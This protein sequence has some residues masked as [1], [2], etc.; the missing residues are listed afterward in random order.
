MAEINQI[1]RCYN[2]GAILQSEDPSKEGYVKKET[3]ENAS[4]NFLFCDKCFEIERYRKRS[5]EPLLEPDFLK[6][7]E[8]VK[9]KNA[10]IVY[11]VNVFSFEAS[12]HHQVLEALDGMNLLVVANKFDLL[13]VG[14]SK[15]ETRE[16]VAH[17]FR[18]A[19]L[20]LKADDV[21]LA[22]AFDDET[23]KEI[24]S[25]IYEMKNGRDV[26]VV[27]SAMSGKAT[28]ISSFLRIF[29]NLSKG[30]IV[31]EPY[32]GTQL[33]CMKIPFNKKTALYNTPGISMDNSVLYNIDKATLREIY[34][35]KPVKARDIS[36]TKGYCFYIGGIAMVELLEG[37]KTTFTC[38]FHENCLLHH[39][40]ILRKSP[41]QRFVSQVVKKA[42][43][44]S[45][46]SIRSVKD[47]DVYD[48]V[49]TESN[50][51]DIGILGLGWFT[52]LANHQTLRIYVP[53]GV[54][55]YHSRPKVLKKK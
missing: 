7:L 28:L 4:Q 20:K 41:D 44:P 3:L 2:C 22:S 50:Q 39:T 51:R 33:D 25:R 38:Y 6:L 15:E 40:H 42:L 45:L 46:P 14:T 24:M 48:V 49:V 36:L 11:V 27:G 32:P 43:K 35:T 5:N 8:D 9:K 16:Y 17:R 34:L 30:A 23:A 53:K 26:F 52:F 10:L 21:I 54:S 19:G 47:L 31:T 13:P 29:S 18:A 37:E 55:I 1:R 12:F